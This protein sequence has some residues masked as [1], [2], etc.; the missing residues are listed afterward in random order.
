MKP[1]FETFCFEKSKAE[2]NFIRKEHTY[3]VRSYSVIYLDFTH[4]F[5]M[6]LIITSGA[7]IIEKTIKT[8]A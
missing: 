3:Y 4:L 6:S 7:D 2:T 1:A 8:Q 5:W